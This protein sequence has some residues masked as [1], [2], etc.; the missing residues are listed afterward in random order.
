MRSK[1]VPREV[2][3][4]LYRCLFYL[5]G[6]EGT[7]VCGMKAMYVQSP[8][9]RDHALTHTTVE[10]ALSERVPAELKAHDEEPE[11]EGEAHGADGDSGSEASA[12]KAAEDAADD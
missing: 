9:H 4:P 7:E 8:V 10:R 11:G 5:F 3:R 6:C 12:D 1:K 2:Y